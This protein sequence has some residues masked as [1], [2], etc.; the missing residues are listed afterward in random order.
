MKPD[1]APAG[2]PEVGVARLP[3][4]VDGAAHDGDLE[5]LGI[6]AQALLDDDREVLDADVV[7]AARRTGDHHRPALAQVQCL[8][9]LPGRLDLLDRVGGEGD[10]DRVADPV[11]EQGAD[12]DGALDR[13]RV[14]AS[15]PP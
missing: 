5:R 1:V 14:R 15:P 2:D 4:S 6:V 10:A 3:R 9:D 8:E 11:G 13:P 7:P 12:A